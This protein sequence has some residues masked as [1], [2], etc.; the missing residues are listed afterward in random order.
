MKRRIPIVSMP[1]LLEY[2][3]KATHSTTIRLR[4][5]GQPRGRQTRGGRRGTRGSV[6]AQPAFGVARVDTLR[7]A[8]ADGLS[9]HLKHFLD[10][11]TSAM[12]ERVKAMASGV[13]G[14]DGSRSGML[15]SALGCNLAKVTNHRID[16][17]I[18]GIYDLHGV[19]NARPTIQ[20]VVRC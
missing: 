19:A 12:L 2:A 10:H 13:R 8:D 3:C 7:P 15:L 18:A 11:F 4:Q 6:G 5:Y 20:S 1:T 17:R 16:I 9:F 14:K